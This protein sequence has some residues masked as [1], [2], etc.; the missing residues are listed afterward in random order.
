MYS[1]ANSFERKALAV[2][3]EISERRSNFLDCITLWS[4]GWVTLVSS[5]L[6]WQITAWVSFT[7][8][9]DFLK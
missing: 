1:I 6:G 4:G 2:G 9:S 7:V 3:G 8:V 5:S